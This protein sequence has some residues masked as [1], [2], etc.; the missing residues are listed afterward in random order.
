VHKI[1][2]AKAALSGRFLEL[3]LPVYPGI[4]AEANS[5]FLL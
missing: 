3:V 2:I 5:L 4:G 1:R